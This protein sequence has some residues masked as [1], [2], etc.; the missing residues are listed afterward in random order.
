MDHSEEGLAPII[1]SL[2]GKPPITPPREAAPSRKETPSIEAIGS[3]TQAKHPRTLSRPR[4]VTESYNLPDFENSWSPKFSVLR[5]INDHGI[6]LDLRKK[7]NADGDD[8]DIFVESGDVASRCAVEVIGDFCRGI[9]FEGVARAQGR[10]GHWRSVWLDE[11]SCILD[12]EGSGDARQCS[13]PLT[14]TGLYQAL[15]KQR[16]NHKSLPDAARRLIYISDLDPVCIHALAATASN[17]QTPVLRNAIYKHLHFQSSIAVGFPSAGFLTFDLSLHLPFFL[18]RDTPPE[19]PGG[20]VNTKPRRTW[21]DLSFL[22]LDDALG[23]QIPKRI[24]G[25][26]DVHISCVVTGSD[27]WRWVGYGFVDAEVD[28]VLHKSSEDDLAFDQIAFG[29]LKAD[30]PIWRPR[31]YWLKLFEVRIQQVM[32]EWKYLIYKVELGVYRYVRTHP[33]YTCDDGELLTL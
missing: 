18:L 15:R 29:A 11:R 20:N 23:K 28:G 5:S 31:D 21:T 16:H 26:Y 1:E 25:M 4:K 9:T 13:N 12:L 14:A 19:E 32:R 7:I 30:A 10:A 22:K 33:H 27:D 24:W 17:H 8:L 2:Q 6:L 3:T